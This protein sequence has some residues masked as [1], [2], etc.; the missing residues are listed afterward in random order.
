VEA[1]Y[2]RTEA[3]LEEVEETDLYGVRLSAIKELRANLELIGTVTKELDRTPTLNLTLNPEYVQLRT[4]ILL[5]LEPHAEAAESVS[6][7]M[8]EIE[9]GSAR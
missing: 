5:A 9:N 1:L 3:V 4:A 8:L 2:K 7:A 6:R